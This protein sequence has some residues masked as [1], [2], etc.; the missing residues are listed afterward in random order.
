[1]QFV[2]VPY[3][4]ILLRLLHIIWLSIKP[5][6]LA[7]VHI[8]TFYIACI[9]IHAQYKLRTPQTRHSRT[10]CANNVLNTV[11]HSMIKK[12]IVERITQ[13]ENCM[14]ATK[15][16]IFTICTSDTPIII[17]I[18]N[19]I[20]IIAIKKFVLSA[21]TPQVVHVNWSTTLSKSGT[22]HMYISVSI[23]NECED[24]NTTYYISLQFL[25]LHRVS[26]PSCR[27]TT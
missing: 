4:E 13:I 12:V 24:Q 19:A 5:H 7:S 9:F 17:V 27:Q 21:R 10:L 14:A 25:F 1:M 26:Y 15:V 18:A 20:L 3:A 2:H 8:I 6:I 22:A 16:R 11:V 23:Y